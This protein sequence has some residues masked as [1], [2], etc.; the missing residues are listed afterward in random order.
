MSNTVRVN[1]VPATNSQ[2]AKSFAGCNMFSC[3]VLVASVRVDL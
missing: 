2:L 1:S 3:G